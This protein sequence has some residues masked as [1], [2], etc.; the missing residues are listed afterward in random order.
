L[1]ELLHNRN[2][3]NKPDN[4]RDMI[5]P[6]NIFGDD[7]L[8]KKARPLQGID[9]G[10]EK[11][12]SSMF[13]TLYHTS[14][15]GLAAPQV[16]HSIQLVVADISRS[17]RGDYACEKPIVAI[18]PHILS[19]N[20]DDVTEEN[21]LSI[22]GIRKNIVRPAAITLQYRNEHFEEKTSEFSGLLA[23]VLQHE[24]DHLHG[25][26]FIDRLTP[27]DREMIQS[28]LDT[29]AAGIVPAEIAHLFRN[30]SSEP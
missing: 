26:L 8:R 10:I 16:G 11:L 29:I 24:I 21:C 25:T 20:G 1:S 27:L 17:R 4:R 15:I 7:I 23:R 14:G 30:S 22:P 5:L 6:L 9:T 2:R 13:E 19:A 28:E 12:V 3:P 18:N